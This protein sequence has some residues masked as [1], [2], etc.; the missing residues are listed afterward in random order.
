MLSG[1]QQPVDRLVGIAIS[2]RELPA[3]SAVTEGPGRPLCEAVDPLERSDKRL[4]KTVEG[5]IHLHGEGPA[6]TVIRAHGLAAATDV[7]GMPLRFEHV[8]KMWSKS[9]RRK[10][11]EGPLRIASI[12][13]REARRGAMHLHT[14]MD[15]AVHE[16]C[17]R[18]IVIALN[19]ENVHLC[20][21][22]SGIDKGIP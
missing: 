4:V 7:V 14:R 1:L 13:S 16:P 17:R 6:G 22:Q 5:D 2:S 18:G 15:Q 12:N 11:H 3:C 10:D 20:I 9:L 8:A 21:P 19:G